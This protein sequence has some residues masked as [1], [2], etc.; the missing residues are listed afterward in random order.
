MRLDFC[1]ACGHKA[2]LNHHHMV[3]RVL[4][5]PDDEN[6]MLTLC[7]ECHGKV[8][9][10]EWSYGHANPP[11]PGLPGSLEFMAAYAAAMGEE[12]ASVITARPAKRGKTDTY[13][14]WD[15]MFGNVTLPPPTTPRIIAPASVGRAYGEP[16]LADKAATLSKF[17][18]YRP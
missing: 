1:V 6:N 3:P 14:E 2:D 16:T 4:G 11:L 10:V 17:P 9:G 12:P 8:H 15:E 13:N 18:R 5:G 7:V